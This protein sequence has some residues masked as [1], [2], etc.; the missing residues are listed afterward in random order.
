M[1]VL[2]VVRRDFQYSVAGILHTDFVGHILSFEAA[3]ASAAVVRT[4]SVGGR[5]PAEA[6]D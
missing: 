3:A 4:R 1:A 5:M 6:V 2:A